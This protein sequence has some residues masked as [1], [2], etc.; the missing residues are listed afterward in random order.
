MHVSLPRRFYSVR[1]AMPFVLW[2]GFGVL[3]VVPWRVLCGQDQP[4][5]SIVTPNAD[6]SVPG[7]DAPA[8]DEDVEN[9]THRDKSDQEGTAVPNRSGRSLTFRGQNAPLEM[10]PL[11][12]SPQARGPEVEDPGFMESDLIT[13]R[14]GQ[15]LGSLFRIG[16]FTG[17][18]IGRKV[19]IFPIEWMPYSLVENNLFFGDLR[20]FK[21]ATDTWGANFGGGYRR[22]IP[23]LDRILGVNAFFDYDNTSGAT[24]RQVGFGAEWLGSL[25][26][27][28]G[29][30][31]L[32]TGPSAQ[33]LSLVNVDGTQQFI[34][35]NLFVNQQR[36]IANALHG[37]DG[38][39]GV[40]LPG[41]MA[42]RHDVRVFG[43]GY[44]YEG[45]YIQSFGGWRTRVQA[46]V[47]P[48]VALQLEVTHDQQFKTNV[49]FG[50]SWSYGGFKQSPDQ[51]KTQYDRMTTPVIRN[52]NMIVGTA[53]VTD[54]GV[55]VINPVTNQPYFFEHVASY[56]PA[57]GDGT[58]E[59]PFKVFADAQTAPLPAGT[60]R[61]IIFVH[62]GSV[63]TGVNV[64]LQ[65]NVR[66][67]GESS[68]VQ[69]VVATTGQNSNSSL[70]NL[71]FLPHPTTGALAGT[72][73]LFQNAP[74]DG[75]TL[76][77]NS[78]FSGFNVLSPTG[79]GIVG[80]G[81]TGSSLYDTVRQTNVSLSGLEGVVLNNTLG[82]VSFRGDT[83]ND[84]SSNSTTFAV[85]GTK[86][87]VLFTSDTLGGTTPGVINN[88]NGSG[89]QALLIDGTAARST[90]DFTNSTVND[91]T[92]N[93]I[94]ISNDAGSVTLGNANVTNGLGIGLNIFN[95]SG[96]IVT[97]GTINISGSAGD[98]IVVQSL[99]A[100]GQVRFNGTG[101]TPFDVVVKNRQGRGIY[102]NNNAGNVVFST[103]VEVDAAGNLGPAAIE[104]QGSSGSASF[105]NIVINKDLVNNF[106]GAGILIGRLTDDNTGSF[107]VNG[108]TVIN[109]T[110]GIGI[111]VTDDKSKVVF[112]NALNAGTTT[113]SQRNN[114]GIEVLA[115]HGPVTFNG[116]TT[117]NNENGVNTPAIDIRQNTIVTDTAGA[118]LS[119]GSVLFNTV[120]VEGAAGPPAA[121][122]GG[123]GVN[124][125]GVNLADA[126][127]APV[128]FNLLNIGKIIPTL[129]GTALFVDHE[130]QGT[131]TTATGLTIAAGTISAVGGTAVDI[132]NSDITVKLTSVSSAPSLTVTP[133]FGINLVDDRVIN[134]GTIP[135]LDSFMFQVSSP[136]TVAVSQLTGGDIRGAAI[137]GVN[138]SQTVG[139][140]LFQTG[141]VSL[142]NMT[143]QS[144]KIGIRA[145]N[146][147]QLNVFNSNISN[148][149]G[150][151]GVDVGAGIDAS[152]LPRVDIQSSQFTLNGTTILDHAIY[153]HANVPLLQPP[154]STLNNPTF[155]RYLWN[156]SNNTNTGIFNAGFTGAAGT[157]DLVR[158]QG[159]APGGG[160][161][162]YSVNTVPIQTFAVPLVF[163][164]E[165]NSMFVQQGLAAQV[166]GVAVN[167]TGQI[168]STSSAAPLISS[169]SNNSF[170]LTG[171]DNGIAINNAS[172]IYTTNFLI[173]ANTLSATGGGNNGLFVN[174]FSQ[175]NLNIGTGTGNGN[176]FTFITPLQNVNGTFIDNGMNIS[177]INSTTNTSFI[178][179]ANN[180]ITMSGGPQNQGILFPNMQAPA[181][182]TFNNNTISIANAQPIIGQAIDFASISKPTVV[183]GGTVSNTVR[184]NGSTSTV[185]QNAWFN[186]QPVN[187]TTG[188][189]IIN[190]F[191]GP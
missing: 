20:A 110:F 129:N 72:R 141:G 111:E 19:S 143:I 119:S 161:L 8:D 52:Y 134:Q 62:A 121:G 176:N 58:V 98:S 164:F 180:T 15:A 16:G 145:T 26:D 86:G 137:A 97:D 27:L 186:R 33:Q 48:S 2:L 144:N 108:N 91:T 77:S 67:L 179:L 177:V 59:H 150:N 42:Q 107:I 74:G 11:Q 5:T 109:N 92:G 82:I 94:Q 191:P 21:G 139:G 113:I 73:P 47:I 106:S 60:N 116:T 136:S 185:F 3:A 188:Q 41:A 75:V 151:T 7:W 57:G 163:Q 95:D 117:I 53:Y 100:G 172:T 71:L 122:F 56:A 28:R 156:I 38:E 147:E 22:Y 34:G 49:V 114:I 79:R 189:I 131:G 112:A 167:W 31:Y 160:D 81:I 190:G 45:A 93:G 89:G 187:A 104:Y 182:V 127:P 126:N 184:I 125:G 1:Q 61:D 13:G 85:T 120:N 96:L 169:I 36:T 138:L 128:N 39:I 90:V 29:N 32:P 165:N 175:T 24:F 103:G 162:Q 54:T 130:G 171:G 37:F 115:N 78:E 157:G 23:A 183:L 25:F 166:S 68:G 178:N 181:T 124:I 146:L 35:H 46:N 154:A 76:A 69:H 140:G 118:V 155:G 44:W 101:T 40:P 132:R 10:S 14:S 149:V 88:V 173:N 99:A 43:G 133:N 70:G 64:N 18:A 55:E 6:D 65:E 135:Q 168:D 153:L 170:I 148:N 174:N 152:N 80:D 12:I 30:A 87:T 9:P 142:N 17:P 83:I 102:L 51:P 123:V 63:F 50:G 84:P 4:A 66:V 105:N 158:I 159:A